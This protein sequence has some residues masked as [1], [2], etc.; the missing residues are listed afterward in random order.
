MMLNPSKIFYVVV[1][2]CVQNMN[3]FQTQYFFNGFN[4][5]EVPV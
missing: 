1:A 4:G 3:L 5:A 2:K